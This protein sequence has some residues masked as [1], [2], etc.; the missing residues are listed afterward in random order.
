MALVNRALILTLALA[1]ALALVAATPAFAAEQTLTATVKVTFGFL[2]KTVMGTLVIKNS[3][4]PGSIDMTWTFT[5]TVDGKQASAKGAGTGRWTGT[6]YEGTVTRIDTWDM[7]G[8]PRPALPLPISLL[9]GV[10]RTIWV[11]PGFKALGTISTP[12]VVE[13]VEKL[14]PPFQKDLALSVTNAPGVQEI[15]GLPPTGAGPEWL[16]LLALAFVV[17]G[18]GALAASRMLLRRAS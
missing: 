1:L 5:G 10:G 4:T 11:A 15:K 7:A 6:S 17:G 9:Q 8:L 14:P 2:G 3:G 12:L 18:G 16:N 13:G